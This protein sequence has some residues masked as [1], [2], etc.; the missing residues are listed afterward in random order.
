MTA[1]TLLSELYKQG[2][3]LVIADGKLRAR[4]PYGVL[5]PEMRQAISEH[6]AELVATLGEGEFPDTSLPAVLLIPASTPNDANS[7]T[8]CIAAQ[9]ITRPTARKE[10]YGTTEES[11]KRRTAAAFP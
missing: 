4:A 7:I 9:R 5:I 2:V 11:E 3:S 10:S 1:L 6:K 8:E